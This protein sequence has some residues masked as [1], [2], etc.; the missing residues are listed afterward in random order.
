MI[1]SG[2]PFSRTTDRWLIG[3]APKRRRHKLVAD[4]HDTMPGTSSASVKHAAELWCHAK[5][6]EDARRYAHAG[7]LLGLATP[8][9]VE[10]LVFPDRHAFEGCRIARQSR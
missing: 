2:S 1:S 10:H 9:N 6:R 5:H 7:H 8:G 3:P 4:D